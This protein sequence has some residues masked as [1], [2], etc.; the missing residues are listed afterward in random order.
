MR[1]ISECCLLNSHIKTN[2][3]ISI[4]ANFKVTIY[5]VGEEEG[6]KIYLQCVPFHAAKLTSKSP[7]LLLLKPLLIWKEKILL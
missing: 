3:I 2:I 1:G 7:C 6:I 4:T 5:K